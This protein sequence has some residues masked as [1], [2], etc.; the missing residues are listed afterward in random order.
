MPP[1]TQL[2]SCRFPPLHR[3][4]RPAAAIGRRMSG[5][6][7][8]LAREFDPSRQAFGLVV[9][10]MTVALESVNGFRDF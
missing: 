2:L 4:Q 1:P 7:D 9:E 8:H 10:R 6:A 3:R 5:P